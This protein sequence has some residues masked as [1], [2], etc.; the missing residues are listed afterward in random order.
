MTLEISV[1]DLRAERDVRAEAAQDLHQRNCQLPGATAGQRVRRRSQRSLL[2]GKGQ[3]ASGGQADCEKM[4]PGR[5]QKR[6]RR[7]RGPEFG[8]VGTL[9]RLDGLP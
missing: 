8:T 3:P 1:R 2:A 7:D 5:E 6:G 4:V 9:E